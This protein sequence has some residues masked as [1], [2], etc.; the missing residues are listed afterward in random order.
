MVLICAVT[1][2]EVA[3]RDDVVQRLLLRIELDEEV[4]V[5]VGAGLPA[6]D[7]AEEREA[8][9]AESLDLL[10]G[11]LQP[12]DYLLLGQCPYVHLN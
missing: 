10:P 4:H 8:Q 6:H 12:L 1:R 2:P 3:E 7:G 9:H 5:A 11:L